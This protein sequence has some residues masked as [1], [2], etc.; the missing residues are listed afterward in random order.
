MPTVKI[1]KELA[2]LPY[3]TIEGYKQIASIDNESTQTARIQ[4]ARWHKAGHILRLKRG[5]YMTRS[6]FERHSSDEDFP[7]AV[8][9]I[10]LPQS[11]V[12][13]IFVLQ[14]AEIL[15]ELTFPITAVTMKNTRT[16]TNEIGTFTYQHLD[17]RFYYGFSD[18]AYHGITFFQASLPKALFD[19]FY[20]RPLPS[21]ERRLSYNLAEELRLNLTLFPYEA[22]ETFQ[23]L[24]T[25]SNSPKMQDILKNIQRHV[26]QT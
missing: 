3:F 21:I 24:V 16:I 1:L 23:G 17:S 19:Y 9:A 8:S 22:R 26:W 11:Y 20:L 6:F 12:S 4:L 13:A 18:Q 2:S 5:M 14:R 25:K 7:A 10:L 15:T